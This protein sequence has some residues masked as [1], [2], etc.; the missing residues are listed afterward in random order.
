TGESGTGKELVAKALH[1]Q[2]SRKNQPFIK[3][4]CAAI[5]KTLMESELFGYEKGAFT[6]ATSSKPGRF[7]LAD[8]GTLF[9]DEIGEIPV[10]M[11][12][13]LL[14]AIQE[15]EFERVGGLKT[16]K[17]D[18]RLI[19]A[20]NRDL[21]AEIQRGNFR[22]DLFYRLNVVPLQIPP[23]R[24]RKGDIPLLVAHVIKKFN[25][26]LKKNITGIADDALAALETH[27]W[28]GNIRELENVLERTILFCKGDRI[29][30]ADLQL[31]AT[32]GVPSPTQPPPLAGAPELP[33]TIT[34]DSGGL[35]A[36]PEEEEL[37]GGEISGS[38]KD[39]V[40]AETAR[41]ERELIVKALD[42]T[43]G[44]VTQAA[45]LLKI[46]RKSLQMKM[47]EFGLR[48]REG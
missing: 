43:G 29:E 34:N 27:S 19:T 22:E 23:L 45:R 28:P 17:V 12:V 1:E 48:D 14:R 31:T 18:V 41:V 35:P 8:G 47:K 21:E 25:E 15:S 44:N 10:E 13:K 16:I 39:V 38:L 3:I 32:P 11:Q 5:P 2:S 37:E 26:R 4:N 36:I 7:E 20:T 9:L 30:R 6:G 33:R 24:Q 40:R 46:S 42:E